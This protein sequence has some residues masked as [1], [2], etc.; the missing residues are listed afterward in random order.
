MVWW[1]PMSSGKQEVLSKDFG[2]RLTKSLM[3][4]GAMKPASASSK[5]AM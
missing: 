5:F 2:L 1:W 3:P 4:F